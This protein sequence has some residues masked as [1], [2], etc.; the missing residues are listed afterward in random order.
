[1]NSISPAFAVNDR[2]STSPVLTIK[3]APPAVLVIAPVSPA[4]DVLFTT[5]LTVWACVPTEPVVAVK[6]TLLP[7]VIFVA[8][9]PMLLMISLAAVRVTFPVAVAVLR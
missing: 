4:T 9:A 6:D 5:V 2:P 3:I 1:M 7:A 8:V